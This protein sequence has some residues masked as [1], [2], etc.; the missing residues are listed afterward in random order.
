MALSAEGEKSVGTS[1]IFILKNYKELMACGV[2]VY[3][4]EN[5]FHHTIKLLLWHKSRNHLLQAKPKE[6]FILH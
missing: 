6:K 4:I 3:G 5:D 2:E 1:I